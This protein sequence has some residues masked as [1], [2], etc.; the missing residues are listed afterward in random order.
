MRPGPA[1]ERYLDKVASRVLATNGSSVLEIG[2]GPG[3]DAEYLQAQGVVVHRTDG[4]RAFVDRLGANGHDARPLD[5]RTG[6][7]GG[8]HAAIIA[9]AVLV[10][11]DRQ[12]FADLIPRVRDPLV[13]GG[14]FAFTFKEGDGHAWAAD[15]LTGPRSFTYWT[16]PGVRSG[17]E[18]SGMSLVD[19][20]QW[21]GQRDT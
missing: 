6:D 13:A 7:L 15:K 17:L 11:L 2:S 14:C 9:N 5:V 18:G 20:N 19:A 1:M 3:W 10:H 16:E 12:Q 4:A 8:P 21:D